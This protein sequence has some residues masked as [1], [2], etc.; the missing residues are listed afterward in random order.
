MTQENIKDEYLTYSPLDFNFH[1][2]FTVLYITNYTVSLDTLNFIIWKALYF[3]NLLRE[4]MH[5]NPVIENRNASVHLISSQVQMLQQQVGVLAENQ[6]NSDDRFSRVKQDN[7]A[8]QERWVLCLHK[9]HKVK[10]VCFRALVLHVRK[11]HSTLVHVLY[12]FLC[13]LFVC[14]NIKYCCI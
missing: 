13:F 14:I 6:V 11:I 1:I 2:L 5:S 4:F 12:W 10:L 8:Y 3:T 9:L 7:A